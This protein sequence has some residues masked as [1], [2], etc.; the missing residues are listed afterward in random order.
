MLNFFLETA[1]PLILPDSVQKAQWKGMVEKFT[2]LDAESFLRDLTGQ[3]VWVAIKLAAA[4]VIYLAGRWIIARLIHIVDLSFERRKVDRSLRSFLRS[5][6]KGVIYTV[7]VLVVVQL[8]GF[9]TTSLVALIAASGFGIG[10]AL[11]GTLQ[12]FAG[13]VMVMF[14]HPYRIGDYIEAQGQAGTVKEIRLFSTVVTTTDNKRI[15]I[16][17]SSISNAIVNNYSA[18]RLRRV[19]WKIAI[20]YGDDVAA[21]RQTILAMLQSDA[22]VLRAPEAPADPFVALSGLG[23]SAVNLVVRAWV[24]N[25]EFWNVF[26]DMNERFYRDLPQQGLHFPFPQLDVHLDK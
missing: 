24:L 6:I 8:L 14:M 11:S 1:T 15:Y 4:L 26:F 22:R 3:L 16:P 12:N 18:E 19:E 7:L 17:N 23:D 5:L 25:G 13:G 9:N 10:M 21:A 2:S 20:S